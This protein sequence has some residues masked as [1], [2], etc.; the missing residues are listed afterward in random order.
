VKR[1][2]SIDGGGVRGALTT[3]FLVQLEKQTGKLCRDIFQMVAG[4][5]TGALIASA[6]AAGIPATTIL[7][8]YQ[9]DCPKLFH[10]PS[11]VAMGEAGLRGYA[12]TSDAI[13][14]ILRAR[15]GAAANWRLNDCPLRILL[16]AMGVSGHPWYFV[17]DNPK[18]SGVTGALSLLD[19]AVASASAPIYFDGTYVSPGPRLVGWC[20]DGGV[21]TTGNPVHQACVEAFGY[22]YFDPHQTKV[23]SLGT[24]FYP[25]GQ[26]NRPGSFVAT[27]LWTLDTLL[28]APVDE[29]SKLVNFY[30]PGLMQRFN[31]QLPYSIDMADASQIPMLVQLGTRLAAS[32][33]WNAILQ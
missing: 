32:M 9:E 7:E 31:W 16:T 20:F 22:D 6:I 26:V 11:V 25:N 1:I 15:L 18:N 13:R 30:Y 12:Y 8:I 10:L 2:L 33:N 29:Q 17:Q 19:C 14:T 27:L 24:G 23:I 28:D 21:G 4:T 3:C 5:S